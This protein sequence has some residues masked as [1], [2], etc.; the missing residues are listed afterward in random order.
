MKTLITGGIKSGKSR[1]A[2]VLAGERGHNK[3]FVATAEALDDELRD[4]IASHRLERGNAY[5]TIEAPI[6]LAAA[7]AESSRS[8][9]LVVVDCITLWVG[10]LF[11]HFEN[12]PDQVHRRIE[13]FFELVQLS[14]ANLVFVTNEVG[15]GVVPANPLVRAYADEL[16]RVNQRLVRQCDE[17]IFMVSGIPQRLRSPQGVTHA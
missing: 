10:N 16:G 13:T 9:D 12:Q 14:E 4:R 17:V 3:G 1:H 7:I 5:Q 8:C 2:L 15:L 11:H 6:D